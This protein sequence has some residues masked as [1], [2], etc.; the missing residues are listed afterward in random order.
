MSS[1]NVERSPVDQLRDQ[2]LNWR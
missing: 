1:F 2:G